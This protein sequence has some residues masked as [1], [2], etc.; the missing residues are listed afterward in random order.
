MLTDGALP[1]KQAFITCF[2]GAA[3]DKEACC[4]YRGYI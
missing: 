4:S 1:E 3:G 2:W